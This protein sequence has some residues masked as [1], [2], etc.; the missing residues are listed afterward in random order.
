MLFCIVV[1]ALSLSIYLGSYCKLASHGPEKICL[2][3]K[4]QLQAIQTSWPSKLHVLDWKRRLTSD[5]V[6]QTA[7]MAN[8]WEMRVW[9]VRMAM[10]IRMALHS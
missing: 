7:Q 5:L 3:N 8:C 9:S 4:E 1:M 10:Q 6:Y 2:H